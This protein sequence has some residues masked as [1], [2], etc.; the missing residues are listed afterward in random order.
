MI[1][2]SVGAIAFADVLRI[3]GVRPS[4]P[5]A[6]VTFRVFKVAIRSVNFIYGMLNFMLFGTLDLM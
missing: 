1:F 5:V 2:N 6:F 3:F 4:S